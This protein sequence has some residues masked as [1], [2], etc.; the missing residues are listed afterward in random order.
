ME[1]DRDQSSIDAAVAGDDPAAVDLLIDKTKVGR[2]MHDEPIEFDKAAFVEQEVEPLA[3]RELPLVMLGLEPCR[4][5]ALLRLCDSALEKLELVAHG[6]GVQP[7]GATR[8]LESG[9]YPARPRPS[10]IAKRPAKSARG[11]STNHRR[12]QSPMSG[13]ADISIVRRSPMSYSHS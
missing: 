6:H 11:V 12:R 5:A 8:V 4:P 1:G 9:G 13:I 7:S 3:C 10:R 2:A